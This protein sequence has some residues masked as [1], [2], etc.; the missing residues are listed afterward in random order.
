MSN[1]ASALSENLFQREMSTNSVFDACVNSERGRSVHQCLRY[2][3]RW[4]V[5]TTWSRNG[6]CSTEETLS[7]GGRANV[8]GF[9]SAESDDVQFGASEDPL[10]LIS[11]GKSCMCP[12]VH[13]QG[14]WVIMLS[15]EGV[16]PVEGSHS[17]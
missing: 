15:R 9:P 12:C 2:W 17:A 5:P 14:L 7:G 10:E 6:P 13:P 4:I 8:L 16:N 1:D 3:F 11:L